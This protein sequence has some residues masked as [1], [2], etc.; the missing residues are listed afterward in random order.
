V[1]VCERERECVCI[2]NPQYVYERRI[3][4]SNLRK[5]GLINAF[6]FGDMTHAALYVGGKESL[7]EKHSL[8][9]YVGHL[10][11]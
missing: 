7:K 5:N 2:Y 8:S 3:K 10:V 11:T 6:M 4:L 1:C 9:M